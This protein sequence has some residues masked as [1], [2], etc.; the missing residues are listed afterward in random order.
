MTLLLSAV[1]VPINTV[2][3]VTS[4]ILIA[5]NE[6]PGK[7][8]VMS[9]LDLPFSIS[10]VVTGQ[11]TC[12]PLLLLLILFILSPVALLPFVP[13][14]AFPPCALAAFLPLAAFSACP[15]AACTKLLSPHQNV[16]SLAAGLVAFVTCEPIG[17]LTAVSA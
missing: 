4:A 12:L 7:L 11:P 14:A 5:R 17:T 8:V 6:F 16:Q 2:F 10:P 1:A 9:M 3:G 15:L 13:L